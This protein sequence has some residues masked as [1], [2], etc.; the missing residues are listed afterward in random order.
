MENRYDNDDER[1]QLFH[2]NI[3]DIR[4]ALLEIE[5]KVSDNNIKDLLEMAYDLTAK[6][7]AKYEVLNDKYHKAMNQTEIYHRSLQE[8]QARE[9][10]NSVLMAEK[11][12]ENK[13]LQ[14]SLDIGMGKESATAEDIIRKAAE[15]EDRIRNREELMG[16]FL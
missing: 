15:E 2:R 13:E 8:A 10:T 5:S 1:D 4:K 3:D 12:Q 6:A 16:K 14:A 11:N 7:R 9:D